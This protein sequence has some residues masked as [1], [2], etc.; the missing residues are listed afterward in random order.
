M[1][2]PRPPPPPAGAAGAAAG[3]SGVHVPEKSGFCANATLDTARIAAAMSPVLA[4]FI[5]LSL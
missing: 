4:K 5:C 1:P 2:P 3:A